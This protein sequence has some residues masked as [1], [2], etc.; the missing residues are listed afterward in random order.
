MSVKLG[1]IEP[2]IRATIAPGTRMFSND[3]SDLYTDKSSSVVGLERA[4]T[5]ISLPRKG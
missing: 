2:F 3:L 4:K 5:S 1:T